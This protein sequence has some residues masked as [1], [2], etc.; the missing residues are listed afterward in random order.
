[1]FFSVPKRYLRNILNYLKPS[2]VRLSIQK[3][4]GKKT[5]E[6][7]RFRPVQQYPM[8]MKQSI[9]VDIV[10]DVVCPWCLIGKRRLEKAMEALKHKY[11]F[12]ISYH[13]FELH[14]ELSAEGQN[15]KEYLVKKFGS[16][17]RYY[18]LTTNVTRIAEGDGL[19]FEFE[20][21]NVMPNTR[22]AHIIIAASKE[23]GKQAQV[24][25][26][27]FNS[28]FSQGVD[29]S[30]DENLMAVAESSGLSRDLVEGWLRDDSRVADIARSEKELTKAGV[31]AVP[32]F[33]INDR[34]ALS[35][36][37]PVEAF[38]NV[39][40]EVADKSRIEAAPS[41]STASDHMK[42]C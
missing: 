42:S 32:F 8:N 33:I 10:S 23:L 12:N 26:A 38:I 22:K 17:S 30:K 35:G 6:L 5:F 24:T 21:Q 25:E 2:S 4:L 9:K 20:K 15:Q 34:Y 31:H 14:P 40:E 37:Q 27:L 7:K 16:E 1:L 28:Y 29:L 36:A 3:Q 39:L 13:P 18:Q 19:H 11:D 41:C